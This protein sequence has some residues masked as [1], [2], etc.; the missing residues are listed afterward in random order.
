MSNRSQDIL[1]Q[2]IRSMEKAEKRHFKLYIKRS[3]AKEDLKIVRLFDALD[4]QE[5]YDEKTLLKKLPGT[6]K[7]QLYNL[8]THLYREI[9]A[10]LRLL[11]SADSI[12]LQLNE[13]FD[14]AHILYKKGLFSQS[15]KILDRAKDTARTHQ[16][17]YFLAQVVGL[18]K[19]IENLHITHSLQSRAEELAAEANTVSRHIDTVARLSNL[20]LQLFS[21]FTRHGHARNEKD[22]AG[23]KKF[24]QENLRIDAHEF[25][26]FYEQL[27]LFQSYCWYAFIRQDFLQY[28]RYAQKWVNLFQ[29]QPLMI[30][31]ETSHYIKGLHYL[32]NAHFDLR[33]YKQFAI[34][35]KEFEAFAVTSRVQDHDN[36]RIQAF[37]YISQ[38]KI[39]QHFMLGTFKE[40]LK[41]V[42]ALEA[43]LK[44]NAV[45]LDQHRIM[46]IN[47]KIATLYFGSGDYSKSIDYLQKIINESGELRTDLQ[48]YARLV[49]LLSHY[50][51]KNYDILDSLI[52][53]VFRFMAKMQN[54]TV[55]EEEIFRF[56]RNSF[57][58]SARQLKPELEKFLHKIKHLEKNRFETR[59]F[60]YLDIISWVEAKVYGKSMG[61]VIHE[62]Y[63]QS[64]RK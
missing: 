52:K 1:F 62:K 2:L 6:E 24:M 41:A 9:L 59:S 27:Y 11:K 3:S 39:N 29:S 7:R 63:L 32:L 49:H 46:V 14:Y 17:F 36:F 57:N 8:K 13:Q 23:V 18:E 54:L 44:E 50:E 28:Y 4:K 43:G 26:G 21:W 20:S 37:V 30:R 19:R 15:L 58:M 55:V 10:S 35:L 61:E 64:K 38:A 34:V 60:A 45:F 42:P 33:N 16:K 53:S 40:G 51:L 12:D 48:C 5:I 31:V 25:G 47:Y 56:L 22:E